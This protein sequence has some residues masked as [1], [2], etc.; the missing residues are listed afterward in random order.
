MGSDLIERMVSDVQREIDSAFSELIHER[1][2]ASSG[3]A[4]WCPSTDVYENDDA[5]VIVADLPGV[6]PGSAQ[7]IAADHRVVLCGARMPE[8]AK[9]VGRNLLLERAS[10]RFCRSLFLRHAVDPALL[11]VSWE[12]G[13][14][15]AVLPKRRKPLEGRKPRL[16]LPII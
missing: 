16:A 3:E 13:M 14:L 10:G 12:N 11:E 8:G 4:Q 7:C 5:Y 9:A 2:Q 15:R 1:W 6:A